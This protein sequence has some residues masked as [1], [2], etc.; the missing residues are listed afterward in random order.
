MKSAIFLLALAALACSC[1]TPPVLRELKTTE[2][3]KRR[4]P[5]LSRF[6]KAHMKD[7]KVFILNTWKV[8]TATNVVHGYGLL[9]DVN[10]KVHE[11]REKKQVGNDPVYDG[12]HVALSDVALIETNDVDRAHYG[13]LA[14]VTGISGGLAI[15]CAANP[16]ACFG[17]CPTFYASDGDTSK[18]MA[19]G[20]STSVAPSLERNDI[21]MLFE[22]KAG[23]DFKLVV[24]NEAL[25]THCIESADLLVFPEIEGEEVYTTEDGLFYRTT[26][27]TLP[28]TFST[29]VGDMTAKVGEADGVEYY[30]LTDS[31]NINSKEW[32]DVTFDVSHDGEY[33]LVIGK[34]QTLL[35]TFLMYQALA[36]MGNSVTYWMSEMERGNIKKREGIFQLLGGIEVFTTMSGQ[37][38]FAGEL[39]ETGPIAVDYN[40]VPVGRHAPGEVK[41]RVK[42]NKGLWRIDYVSLVELHDKATPTLVRPHKADVITGG[43]RAPLEKLLA[44][45]S[46]LVTYP[47]DA[48][49]LHYRLPY[50]SSKVFLNSR[51]YYLEWIREEWL[52][53]QDLRMFA[54]MMRNPAKYLRN[55]APHFKKIEPTMEETFWNSR[56]EKH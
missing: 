42:L 33:G 5:L 17:S 34:R 38:A 40:V 15:Y 56:Y 11:E 43:E 39:N 44:A 30:S 29:E 24:T 3:F 14:V 20:F 13:A 41:I 54:L 4:T 45:D 37:M 18:I 36:H 52:R 32:I 8:D 19:E 10:R 55:A 53:E 25:E 35:T 49:T 47:G 12:F 28:K 23:E 2:D 51:G 6:I 26:G 31:A 22:A 1:R 9:L 21:D 50:K 7:G 27:P 16:K 48:Y 46:Y